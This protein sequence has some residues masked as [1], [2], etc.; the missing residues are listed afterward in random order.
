MMWTGQIGRN[1]RIV[2]VQGAS[3]QRNEGGNPEDGNLP[4]LERSGATGSCADLLPAGRSSQCS[5]A[6]QSRQATS[7]CSPLSTFWGPKS[8][9]CLNLQDAPQKENKKFGME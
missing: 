5:F 2:R 4:A 3:C 6:F 7:F 9:A 1:K 8:Q